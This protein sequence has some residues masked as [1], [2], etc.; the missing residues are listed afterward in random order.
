M[1][2]LIQSVIRALELFELVAKDKEPRTARELAAAA[3]L[4]RTTAYRLL[5]TLESRGFVERDP[6]T[7]TYRLGYEATVLA[8]YSSHHESLIRRARPVLEALASEVNETVSLNVVAQNGTVAVDQIDPETPV[9][10]INYVDVPL[11][12]HC[13]SSGKVILASYSPDDFEAYFL[14]PPEARTPLTI[15]DKEQL[16]REG[17]LTRKRGFGITVGEQDEGINGVSAPVLDRAENLVACVSVSGPTYRLPY[18]RLLE[19]GPRLGSAARD[20]EERLGASM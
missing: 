5:A 14:T 19:L 12:L 18:D 2:Q 9:R 1:P 7:Q 13:T 17:S 4:D 8:A 11:P 15:V 16:R 6:V 10:V 20:I 3:G